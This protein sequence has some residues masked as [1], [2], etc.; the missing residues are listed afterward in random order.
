MIQ[1][2][3]FTVLLTC[4]S[5]YSDNFNSESNKYP[6]TNEPEAFFLP[7]RYQ[8]IQVKLFHILHMP[9][10]LFLLSSKNKNLLIS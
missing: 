7:D 5:F 4:V 9:K 1:I 3:F 10:C 2:Y 6:T 8:S